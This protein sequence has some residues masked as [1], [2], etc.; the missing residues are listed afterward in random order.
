MAFTLS[1]DHERQRQAW[2]EASKAGSWVNKARVIKA[3]LTEGKVPG[4]S[5]LGRFVGIEAYEAEGGVIGRDLFSDPDAPASYWF[6]QP[7]ILQR[8]AQDKLDAEAASLRSDWAWVETAIDM[9]EYRMFRT[10][11]REPGEEPEL[12]ADLAAEA[13]WLQ[14]ELEA[15]ES[16][17]DLSPEDEQAWHACRERLDAIEAWPEQNVVYSDEIR[18][19]AGCIVTIGDTGD[20][21]VI[22]G[23]VKRDDDVARPE[24][25][26][27]EVT[28]DAP[29][30]G[31]GVVGASSMTP[32]RAVTG[33]GAAEPD[34]KDSVRM[35]GVLCQDL[36]AHRTQCLQAALVGDPGLAQDVLIYVLHASVLSSRGYWDNPSELT[37]RPASLSSTLDDLGDTQ[38]AKDLTAALQALPSG[39]A[40][41]SIEAQFDAIRKL[42]AK[43]KAALLA[44]SVALSL[45]ERSIEQGRVPSLLDQIGLALSGDAVV[46]S[47]WRPTA[48]NF[49]G[50]IP[51]RAALAIGREVLGDAWAERHARDK[52][53]ALGQALEAAFAQGVEP[54]DGVTPDARARAASWLPPGMGVQTV[55]LDDTDE[56]CASEA[57]AAEEAEPAAAA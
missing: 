28:S 25:A 29:R 16:K 32:A 41:L 20:L 17:D 1:D 27:G 30:Q 21:R 3:F 57:D 22:K 44:A 39:L 51:M 11:G 13:D 15:L 52:K 4:N 24:Q 26:G 19:R 42:G 45:K 48:A 34:Q 43:E 8:L 5:S 54:V 33:D 38:A 31:V 56:V 36:G 2:A 46:S 53:A 14:A 37:A 9:D 10:F 6:E 40:G 49:W 35:S 47:R 7:A 55:P 12:P 18:A 50:R 23:L